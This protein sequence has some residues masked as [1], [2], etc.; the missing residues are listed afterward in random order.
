[1]SL[2]TLVIEAKEKSGS[3]ITANYAFSQ[4]RKVF[5]V[6]GSIYSLN[7]KG[8]NNLIKKGAK[9]VDNYEDILQELKLTDLMFKKENIRENLSPEEKIIL[10]ALFSEP[11]YIDKIIEKT[12]LEASK[13]A[14]IVTELEMEGIIRN[15]GGNIFSL[16][17]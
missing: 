7:S 3:L 1:L 14:S 5:A 13:V 15:L 8:T 16:K 11:L 2:G 17:K 6:P 12:K 10:D 4:K 9:L